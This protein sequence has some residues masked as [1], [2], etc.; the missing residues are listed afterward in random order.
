MAVACNPLALGHTYTRGAAMF[1]QLVVLAA[2]LMLAASTAIARTV[3]F[4]EDETS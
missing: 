3:P 1:A 2:A 4:V